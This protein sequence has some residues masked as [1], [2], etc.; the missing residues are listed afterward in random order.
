VANDRR[1]GEHRAG[2][3][4]SSLTVFSSGCE[5]FS[6]TRDLPRKFQTR[7]AGCQ[8]P[9]LR[10]GGS[11]A[12]ATIGTHSAAERP[13]FTLT[14]R[15]LRQYSLARAILTISENQEANGMR[16]C[17][18]LEVSETIAK[19]H[20]GENHGGLFIPWNIGAGEFARKRPR[21]Q[22]EQRA[23]LSSNV[24]T[25]GQELKFTEPGD[26]LQYLYN[27]MR[28]KE[29]G[30]TV[31]SGLRDNVAFPKQTGKAT[32]S[33]VAENPGADVADSNLTLGQ[34]PELAAHVSVLD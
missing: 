12:T 9:D 1:Q 4:K 34:V 33:W 31:I 2:E 29:L 32:G 19:S 14:E 7:A 17:F 22:G 5:L 27:R 13:R 23:G 30:A 26:F 28:V 18:E 25:T 24:A 6:Q 21:T 3:L 15:E 10:D 20:R 16:N 8:K 11:M